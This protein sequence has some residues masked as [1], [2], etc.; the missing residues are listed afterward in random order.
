M[1][2][3]ICLA[4]GREIDA[5]CAVLMGVSNTSEVKSYEA[6]AFLCGECFEERADRFR[7]MRA[8]DILALSGGMTLAEVSLS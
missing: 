7:P 6:V 3:L 5:E 1:N 2:E 4:C 8:S